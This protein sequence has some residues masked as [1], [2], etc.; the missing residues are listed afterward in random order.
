MDKNARDDLTRRQCLAGAAVLAAAPAIAQTAQATPPAQPPA[1]AKGPL[2]WMDMDQAELDAA[3]DQSKY[4]PNQAI[5][6]RRQAVN[7]EGVRA[8]LGAPRRLAYGPT[9]IEGLDLYA[10]SRANAP[11]NIFVHGGAWRA[12]LAKD[13]AYAAELYVHAGAH[14]IVLDF[15]NVIEATGNL[16]AMADQVRRAVAWVHRNARSFG[17]DPDRIYVSGHSSG[18]HLAGVVLVTDWRKDF[19]AP[20]DLVK[21]GLC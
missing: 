6:Q 21:G 15:I 5:V 2:V 9:P 10:T 16:M 4:A 1:R 14:Y 12:G 19:D 20:A 17:G 11:I 13:H 18:A 3:Y 8:R 7:S